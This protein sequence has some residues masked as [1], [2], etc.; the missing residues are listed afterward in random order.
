MCKSILERLQSYN[1]PD[2]TT[3]DQRQ[4]AQDIYDAA[5]C[6]KEL[7]AEIT[8]LKQTVVFGDLNYN[9]KGN[10]MHK[11]TIREMESGGFCVKVGC[12]SFFYLTQEAMMSEFNDYLLN[13]EVAEKKWQEYQEL[14]GRLK[15]KTQPIDYPESGTVTPRP[16]GWEDQR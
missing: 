8:H 3:D 12:Q 14:I 13:R 4:I 15:Q 1:P 7:E 2:R 11:I 16:A 9:K 5:E 10:K 6:I